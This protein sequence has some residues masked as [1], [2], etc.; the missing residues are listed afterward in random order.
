ML[1]L[2]LLRN[3]FNYFSKLTEIRV[4]EK[5]LFFELRRRSHLK[6]PEC[7]ILSDSELLP[8]SKSLEFA[9]RNLELKNVFGE[10]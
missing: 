1:K 9:K 3:L 7:W 6:S 10:V 4:I 2:F 5:G 8:L